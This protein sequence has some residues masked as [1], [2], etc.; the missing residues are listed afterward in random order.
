[1]KW[2]YSFGRVGRRF[3]AFYLSVRCWIIRQEIK[4]LGSKLVDLELD[5]CA[6]EFSIKPEYYWVYVLK[7]YK[8]S[9]I[10]PCVGALEEGGKYIRFDLYVP[11]KPGCD[12]TASFRVLLVDGV[13]VQEV[14]LDSSALERRIYAEKLMYF[15]N[16]D[17]AYEYM[18][19]DEA[20]LAARNELASLEI[21]R[22]L[23]NGGVGTEKPL[24]P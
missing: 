10:L 24:R 3:E 12:I 17:D 9:V 14:G 16:R 4:V 5:V 19:L 21:S 6:T 1:M 20:L 18:R 22:L 8:Q 11:L 15:V 2:G 7:R 13:P 23:L